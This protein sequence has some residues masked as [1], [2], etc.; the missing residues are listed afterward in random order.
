MVGYGLAHRSLDEIEAIGVDEV[1]YRRGHQYLTVVYQLD[2]GCRRLLYVGKKR[3]VRS[4]LGF[5][6]LLGR[7]VVRSSC[8]SA[9]TCGSRI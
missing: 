4:L 5:F 6:R 3:T 7:P 9:R 8:I 1:Q 2:S